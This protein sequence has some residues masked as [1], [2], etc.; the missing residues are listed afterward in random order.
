MAERLVAFWP[1]AV[2]R[3]KVLD[4]GSGTGE[5][6]RAALAVGA[7]VIAAD[8]ALDM[9]RFGREAR[10]PAAAGDAIAL[11]FRDDAFEAV[12]APFSLNHL[13]DPAQGVR[14]AGRV[15]RRL[16][17]STYAAG[18]DHPAKAAVEHALSDV[19]WSRPAWYSQVRGSMASWGTVAAATAVVERGGLTPER[20]E[21][22]DIGFDDFGP[23]E[24]VAWRMGL[25]HAA[26]F[27]A[28]L[29]GEAQAHVE[30]RALELLGPAPPP[31]VRRVIFV[32]ASRP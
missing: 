25:P 29:D 12:L 7:T 17:A 31:L 24:L 18:D 8:L 20:V 19:G 3:R 11:P 22:L 23:R 14:E 15:G 26:N 4:L 10:P 28:T 9:L 2:R 6:S 5:G 13:H 1:S 27:L 32:A 30:A 16:V 21:R